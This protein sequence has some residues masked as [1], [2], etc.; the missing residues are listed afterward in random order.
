[1]TSV[2]IKMTN[3]SSY[4]LAYTTLMFA[5]SHVTSVVDLW[6]HF[7]VMLSIGTYCLA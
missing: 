3:T 4:C 5:C 1:M 6:S 7:T 2:H